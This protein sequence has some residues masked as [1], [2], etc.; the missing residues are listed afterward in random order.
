MNINPQGII[1]ANISEVG[2][3]DGLEA[4]YP[5]DKNTNDY[6]VN[7]K[8]GTATGAIVSQ[9]LNQGCYLFDG[10]NDFITIPRIVLDK[11]GFTISAWMNITDFTAATDRISAVTLLSSSISS[12]YNHISFYNGKTRMEFD[13]NS[14]PQEG[15]NTT[16]GVVANDWFFFTVVVNKAIPKVYIN[17]VLRSTFPTTTAN[18]IVDYIG[19]ETGALNY[20]GFF[21]GKVQDLRFYNR[22]LSEQ[23]INILY[24][25]SG[26]NDVIQIK[27]TKNTVYLKGQLIEV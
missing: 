16:L 10:V 7:S 23:E 17:S 9:G 12:Y 26:G 2:I 25:V 11:S 19:K 14:I 8:H 13:E 3:T 6:S 15:P 20:P 24:D 21:K 18:Y 27:Q 22:A 1:A 4:W 5:L